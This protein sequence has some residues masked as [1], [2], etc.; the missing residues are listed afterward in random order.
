[1]MTWTQFQDVIECI[2]SASSDDDDEDDDD[3]EA[4]AQFIP[5]IVGSLLSS[6]I[7]G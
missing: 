7:S 4:K 3:D 1:M 6:A 5:F 2:R